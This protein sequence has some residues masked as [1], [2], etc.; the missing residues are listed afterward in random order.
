MTEIPKSADSVISELAARANPEKASFFP[1]FFKT[2]PGEYGE[3]DRFL[4]VVVPEQRKVAKAFRGLPLLEVAKLLDHEIH[5]VRLTGLFILVGQY[6]RAKTDEVK[7]EVCAFY[8]SKLDRVNNWDL[9]DSSAPKILGPELRRIQRSD[10]LF[11][12]AESGHLWRERV[13]I[14]STLHF[15]KFQEFSELE[16]LCERFLEHPHDLIHKA[17]GWML[18]EAGK[19][20]LEFLRRCL[21]LWA[22]RMPRTMLRYAIEKLDKSERQKWMA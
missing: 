15:I 16:K 1:R 2:G 13:A 9:V 19:R 8:L 4:G 10:L 18:R 20:D 21:T 22:D 5:E 7:A 17:C 3:G 11:E 14:L 6:E 12:L